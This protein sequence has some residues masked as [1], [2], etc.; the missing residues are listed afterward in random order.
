MGLRVNFLYNLFLTLANYLV[1]LV[2]FPYISRVFGV[3]NVGIVGFV[4]SSINYFILFAT[5][6]ISTIGVR[7]IA[8]VKTDR[9][10]LNSAFSS[11]LSLSS[12]F[13]IIVVVLYFVLIFSV[14]SFETHRALFLIGSA[15][16]IFTVY[17]IEWFY[18]GIENFK[19]ISIRNGVVKVV[20]LLLLFLFVKEKNDIELYFFLTVLSIVVS[21]IINIVYSRKFVT[22][23]LKN[24]RIE[25]FVKQV[26]YI[27]TYS[28]LTSMYTTFNIMYLG[29]V[30][31]SAEVGYYWTALKIYTIV[32]GFYTAFTGVM[33]PRMSGMVM[34]KELD[35]FKEMIQKSF[36]LLLSFVLPVI[37]VGIILTS[38]LIFVL[39]GSGFEGAIRPMRLIMP[40]LLVVG[41]AQIIAIQVLIPL[42]QD[43]QILRASIIGAIVGVV[44]N[45][46]FVESFGS[47]GTA[48]VLL[49]SETSVTLYYVYFAIRKQIISFPFLLIKKHLVSILPYIAVN[50]LL[51]VLELGSFLTIATAIVM[52]GILFLVM[53]YYYI[54][55]QFSYKYISMALQKCEIL[56]KR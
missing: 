36:D 27:G 23:S 42:K 20:Y 18:K 55:N 44:G 16:L 43:G 7:E 34:G 47:V 46:L 22:F 3:V 49:F 17:S 24:I 29:F 53:Q 21:S 2:V 54:R 28:I 33:L 10:R 30:C 1:G 52:N 32:L 14:P 40:L 25:P 4:D 35:K 31:N 11:L 8:R 39:S 56:L 38:H 48:S 51:V 26:V 41:V 6:G 45:V 15:K 12:L 37:V 9:E 5:L 19:F 13:L 50:A